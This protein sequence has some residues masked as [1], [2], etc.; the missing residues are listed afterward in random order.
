MQDGLPDMARLR[1]GDS[2][3]WQQAIEALWK[4]SFHVAKRAPEGVV[5]EVFSEAVAQ[6]VR[7]VRDGKVQDREH[8]VAAFLDILRKRAIDH[9]RKAAAQK[10][11]AENTE[12]LDAMQ[13]RSG[14]PFEAAGNVSSPSAQVEAHEVQVHVLALV[15]GLEP[16]CQRVVLGRWIDCTGG[17]DLGRELGISSGAIRKRLHDCMKRLRERARESPELMEYMEEI[18]KRPKG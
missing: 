4:R 8:L 17:P 11:G 10:R 14:K 15:A 12:S 16:D 5:E 7:R 9:I 2:D 18:L 1:E 13:D 6:L 3:A